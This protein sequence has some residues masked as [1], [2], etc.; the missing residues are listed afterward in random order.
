MEKVKCENCG[1]VIETRRFP[2]CVGV[3]G[4]YYTHI[5]GQSSCY[6]TYKEEDIIKEDITGGF[7]KRLFR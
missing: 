6:F 1:K 2:R 7:F 4:G 3:D 5:N